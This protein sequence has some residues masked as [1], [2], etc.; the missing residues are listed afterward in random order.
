MP[1]IGEGGDAKKNDVFITTA[2]ST[3]KPIVDFENL[4]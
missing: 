3:G 2:S 4:P 1:W